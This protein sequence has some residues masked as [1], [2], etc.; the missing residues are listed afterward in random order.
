MHD[1]I[2][3][4]INKMSTGT[5]AVN[6]TVDGLAVISNRALAMMRDESDKFAKHI[7]TCIVEMD[8]KAE[9]FRVAGNV[10]SVLVQ[11]GLAKIAEDQSSAD[12]ANKI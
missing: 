8:A 10:L 12:A 3:Q 11:E 9:T 4:V 2:T 1:K 6:E 7:V 5:G